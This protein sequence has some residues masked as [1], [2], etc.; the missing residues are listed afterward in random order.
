MVR[1]AGRRH[2]LSVLPRRAERRHYQLH[3]RNP[4]VLRRGQAF[5][6]AFELLGGPRAAQAFMTTPQGE[7]GEAPERVAMA[8]RWGLIKVLKMIHR[9]AARRPQVERS[10]W[11]R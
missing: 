8:S 11:A 9:D 5:H 1:H 7:L 3:Y 6:L 2:V 10:R 4:A